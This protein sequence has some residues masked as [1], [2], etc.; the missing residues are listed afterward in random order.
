MDH[1]AMKNEAK[2]AYTYRICLTLIQW[3]LEL[4]IFISQHDLCVNIRKRRKLSSFNNLTQVIPEHWVVFP[5]R[6]LVIDFQQQW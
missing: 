4:K 3:M 2:V 6:I 1:L 5:E